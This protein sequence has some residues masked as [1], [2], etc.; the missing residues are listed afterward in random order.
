VSSPRRK[1]HGPPPSAGVLAKYAQAYAREAGIAEKRV[2]AWLAYMVLAGVL[3]RFAKDGEGYQ[4]TIK[5]GVALELRLRERARARAT[6]DLDLVLHHSVANL[7]EALERAIGPDSTGAHEYQGFQFE[8]RKEPLLLDNGTSNV[9]L[10][11]SYRGGSWTTISVDIARAEPG[12]ADV[13]LLEAVDFEDALGIAGPTRLPCLPLR[14][15]IAQK[16]HGMTLPPRP[17]KRNERFKDLIDLMLM[18]ALVTDFT[19]LREACEGV[20]QNRGAHGWPPSL[21]LPEHWRDEYAKLAKEIELP[22]TDAGE[23][24]DRVRALIE[25]IKA[26]P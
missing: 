8:R 17:G 24:M 2:R 12:E 6:K 3:E 11:V 22:V 23:A 18:E 4:F 9:E 13:E 19:G 21:D 14:F 1:P 16:I 26:A 5:G 20:F 15:H 10:A 7:A 25:R